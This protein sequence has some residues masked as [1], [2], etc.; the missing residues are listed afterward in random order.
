M[1]PASER[2]SNVIAERDGDSLRD[3]VQEFAARADIRRP[4]AQ[5][6]L[7]FAGR[8]EN[9]GIHVRIGDVNF[10]DALFEVGFSHPHDAHFLHHLP[11]AASACSWNA[12]HILNAL[13]RASGGRPVD[14]SKLPHHSGRNE[15]A[16]GNTRLACRQMRAGRSA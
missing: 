13:L 2:A 1:K 8:R 10:A 12:L 7:D 14:R 4:H 11:H 6:D 16:T 3:F 5:M 15:K 9:R